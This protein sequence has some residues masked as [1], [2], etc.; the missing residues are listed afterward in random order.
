MGIAISHKPSHLWKILNRILIV[1]ALTLVN[2]WYNKFPI[3]I[4]D[5][6]VSKLQLVLYNWKNCEEWSSAIMKVLVSQQPSNGQ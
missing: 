4:G 2:S 3:V 1:E 5:I 6:F